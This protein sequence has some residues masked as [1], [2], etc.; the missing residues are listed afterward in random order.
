M[1]ELNARG[2]DK[3][4]KELFFTGL[5]TDTKPTMWKG[6]RIPQ[7]SIFFEIDTWIPYIFDAEN[8]Q[9]RTKPTEE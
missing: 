7:L 3:N 2:D 9:W 1:V 5:S 6:A 4:Q 8:Q